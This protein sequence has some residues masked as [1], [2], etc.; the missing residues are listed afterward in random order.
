MSTR[1]NTHSGVRSEIF[2]EGSASETPEP[3]RSESF[4]GKEDHDDG[5]MPSIED[6]GGLRAKLIELER[7]KRDLCLCQSRVDEDI[8]AVKRTM[9]LV[10]G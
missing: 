10:S 5:G 4:A 1:H 3:S 2:G 8:Q 6:I 9:Q 7:E